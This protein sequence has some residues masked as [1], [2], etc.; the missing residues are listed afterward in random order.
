MPMFANPIP[1]QFT[2][3]IRRVFLKPL[4]GQE[5]LAVSG[6]GIR[7]AIHLLNLLM[8]TEEIARVSAE[9][10]A[11]ADRD[12]LFAAVYKST[13]GP[14]IGSTVN[15]RAC[16]E[17]FDI[18]FSLD[19]LNNH[20]GGKTNGAT[21][22]QLED[23]TYR[24]PSGCRF[25]LP[26]GEDELAAADAPAERAVE[27]LLERCIL[28]GDPVEH[29]EPVQ[30]AMEQLAPVWQ[31]ELQAVCPECGAEQLFRFDMQSFLL[32]RLKNDRNRTSWEIHRLAAAYRWSHREILD[33]PR[34]LRQMYVQYIEADG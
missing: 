11:T 18:D 7:E 33:L 1:V 14:S 23:G 17:R 24:L 19:D 6:P 22:E 21:A 16:R 5:E 8:E 10:I 3:G 25:R 31:M 12:R 9:K 28:K 20:L 34:S 29:A 2:P 13:Y 30:E 4:R 26:V 27:I 32:N 15:C